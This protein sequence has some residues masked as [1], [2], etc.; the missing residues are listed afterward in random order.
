VK[1]KGKELA[2]MGR[3]SA[4]GGKENRKRGKRK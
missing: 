3:N 2:E 1:T 4:K